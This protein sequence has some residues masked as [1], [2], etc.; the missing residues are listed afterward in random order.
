MIPGKTTVILLDLLHKT[1]WVNSTLG[2]SDWTVR[3]YSRT[4]HIVPARIMQ[5]LEW[6]LTLSV[7]LMFRT[8]PE[9]T[10]AMSEQ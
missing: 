7:S 2:S 5:L 1:C 3:V 8:W 4:V 10:A 9:C 6:S